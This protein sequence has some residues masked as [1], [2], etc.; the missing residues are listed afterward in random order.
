MCCLS[1]ARSCTLFLP[2][3]FHCELPLIVI[4]LIN[5]LRSKNEKMSK[6]VRKK[7]KRIL[8]AYMRINKITFDQY[9]IAYKTIKYLITKNVSDKREIRSK[10][11]NM[12]IYILTDEV[13]K[14]NEIID[15]T[16]ASNVTECKDGIQLVIDDYQMELKIETEE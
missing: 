7:V 10:V 3:I 11:K 1:L 5:K 12:L 13:C 8:G 4:S 6:F 9:C 15:Q 2:N 16:S 14:L